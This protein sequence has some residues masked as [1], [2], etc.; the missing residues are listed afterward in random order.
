[1]GLDHA[2]ADERGDVLLYVIDLAP[3]IGHQ[4]TPWPHPIGGE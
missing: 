1:M 4:T 3:G 2:E